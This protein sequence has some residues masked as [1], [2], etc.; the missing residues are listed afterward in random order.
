MENI[1]P[2]QINYFF[3][4]QLFAPK[5]YFFLKAAQ[6]FGSLGMLPAT[7]AVSDAIRAKHSQ[8]LW[9]DEECFE[10]PAAIPEVTAI[11]Q[12]EVLRAARSFKPSSAPG[13]SGLRPSHIE[14]LLRTPSYS[15]YGKF[16]YSLTELVNILASG[17][18]PIVLA[19]WIAW[20]TL[21][22]LAKKDLS[23]RPIAVGGT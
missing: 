5:Q 16:C 15:S 3:V 8:S 18:A 12:D 2:E 4:G 11:T 9:A 20:L 13:V 23:P 1:P 22:P 7:N 21:T 14:K 6:A 19:P 10:P 17:K